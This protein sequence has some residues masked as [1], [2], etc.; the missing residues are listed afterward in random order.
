MIRALGAVMAQLVWLSACGSGAFSAS[1]EVGAKLGDVL[2]P[3]RVAEFLFP[4][5]RYQQRYNEAAGLS[6]RPMVSR[7]SLLSL[8]SDSIMRLRRYGRLPLVRVPMSE[9]REEHV[10]GF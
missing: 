1:S 2:R 5:M 9:Q 7:T 8:H 3:H 10:I 4:L 6:F